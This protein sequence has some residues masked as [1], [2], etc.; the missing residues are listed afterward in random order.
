MIAIPSFLLK[1]LYVKGSL[2]NNQGGFQ[3]QIKN[4][5]GSGYAKGMLPLA[6]D[7]RELP[8]ESCYFLLEGQEVPFTTV[9]PE[10]PFTLAMNKASTLLAKGVKLEPGLHKLGI[11]FVVQG[12]GK[13]SFEVNDVLPEG[14]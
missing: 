13:M 7:G 4:T 2:S 14:G 12:L 8:M 6:L 1:R 3:F 9:T 10:R 5:L 11:G